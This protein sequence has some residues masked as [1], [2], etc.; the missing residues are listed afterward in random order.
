MKITKT[1]IWEYFHFSWFLKIHF[2]SSAFKTK[3]ISTV[4]SIQNMTA[5]ETTLPRSECW[6]ANIAR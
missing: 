3:I 5:G 4:S 1:C 6:Q 2:H